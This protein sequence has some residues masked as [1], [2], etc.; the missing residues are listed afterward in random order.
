MM[1]IVYLFGLAIVF[2][3]FAFRKAP[4]ALYRKL[5]RSIEV[6]AI[7]NQQIAGVEQRMKLLAADSMLETLA[8]MRER[9]HN[10]SL[11]ILERMERYNHVYQH[12]LKRRVLRLPTPPMFKC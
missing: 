12:P 11:F 7:M 8:Q 5:Q 2:Q 10:L 1:L 4:L 3:Y 6:Y 9:K